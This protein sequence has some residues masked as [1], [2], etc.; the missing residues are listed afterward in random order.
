[1]NLIVKEII[2]K[3]EQTDLQIRYKKSTDKVYH[4]NK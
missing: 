1:M 3:L 2:E 4:N